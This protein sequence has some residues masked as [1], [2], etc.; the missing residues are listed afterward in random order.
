MC[1]YAERDTES[2]DE[3][4]IAFIKHMSAM[5]D[6]GLSANVDI[7]AELAYRDVMIAE[8]EQ[9][10]ADAN[11]RRSNHSLAASIAEKRYTEAEAKLTERD[12]LLDKCWKYMKGELDFDAAESLYQLFL[13][14][15]K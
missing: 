15:E 11:I 6:E 7:A 8:L 13:E 9:Q 3:L 12:K 14:R 5:M 10:L 4:R 1:E 2:S